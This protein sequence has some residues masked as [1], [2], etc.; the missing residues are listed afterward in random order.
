MEKVYTNLYHDR[1]NS[2]EGIRE[3][4]LNYGLCL[5]RDH[6]CRIETTILDAVDT[7]SRTWMDFLE[8]EIVEKHKET[9]SNFGQTMFSFKEIGSRGALRFDALF[10]QGRHPD[11]FAF[12]RSTTQCPWMDIIQSVFLGID[13]DISISVVWTQPGSTDQEWQL[14][15][16]R[17]VRASCTNHSPN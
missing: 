6:D 13:Y 1:Q 7:A 8:Q 15:V 10:D 4:F 2:S 3:N 12:A 16:K 17:P 5:G 9:V 14:A 11:M